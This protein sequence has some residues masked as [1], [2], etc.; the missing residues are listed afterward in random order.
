MIPIREQERLVIEILVMR[1]DLH[2][3]I[4]EI[5]IRTAQLHLVV[6]VLYI[7]LL[8]PLVVNIQ[9]II[10][11]RVPQL[12]PPQESIPEGI[13]QLHVRIHTQSP[14]QRKAGP[15]QLLVRYRRVQQYRRHL[16]RVETEPEIQRTHGLLFQNQFQVIHRSPAQLV[17]HAGESPDTV[18]LG[19]RVMQVI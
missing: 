5:N 16:L 3:E 17:A 8:F 2:L 1:P 18:Q 15:P 13:I 19:Y 4:P 11:E 6:S 12:E 7:I 14:G 9:I 10:L